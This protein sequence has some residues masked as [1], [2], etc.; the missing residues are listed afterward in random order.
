MREIIK[1]LFIKSIQLVDIQ[2]S[3]IEINN[4]WIG[5]PPAFKD[6]ILKT[7]KRLGIIFPKDYK[8]L[9]SITNGFKPSNYSTEPTFNKIEEIDYLKNINPDIIKAYSEIKEIQNDLKRSILIAGKG[10]VQQFL[11]IPPNQKNEKWKYW[12]FAHWIPGEESY[13]NLSH[14]LSD[15]IESIE[16]II[17]E[18]D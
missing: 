8:E 16:N 10:E 12:M 1:K 13:E 7:E 5:N 18:E 3:D 2:Y 4:E 14:Y 6:D 15:T 17:E 9:L 11:L